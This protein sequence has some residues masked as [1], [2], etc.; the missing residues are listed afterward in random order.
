MHRRTGRVGKHAS[1][2]HGAGP[3]AVRRGSAGASPRSPAPQPSQEC[4]LWSSEPQTAGG[5][6]GSTGFQPVFSRARCPCHAWPIRFHH[7]LLV[8]LSSAL[9][10]ALSRGK[11][12]RARPGFTLV[13]LLVVAGIFAVLL[14]AIVPA[15]GTARYEAKRIVCLDHG[16]FA[17]VEFR[18]FADSYAH[19]YR[20][21]SEAYGTRFDAQDFLESLYRVGEFWP[22]ADVRYEA[23]RPADQPL[24]CPAGPPGLGRYGKVLPPWKPAVNPR[25]SVSYAFNR[26]LYRAPALRNGL[27][28]EAP[29]L[30][31]EQI[32]NHPS[33]PLFFEV[34][35]EAAL[36][37]FGSGA[38]LYDVPF[39]GTPDYF[40]R[41]TWFPAL[42]HRGRM[43]VSFVGGHALS[44]RD[45]L[46]ERQWD[47]MHFPSLGRQ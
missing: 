45:P 37:E 10:P 6:S 46:A 8:H 11:R 33:V 16:R 23:Y 21:D 22:G 32:L 38:T 19:G 13:E 4:G 42:R 2:D 27:P 14:A 17:A 26:R 24:I 28:Y 34:D 29:V 30:L 40:Q 41:N 43:T 15:M 31:T 39:F 3:L 9:T 20:G 44:T 35:A 5:R 36:K 25:E 12:G 1:A 7:G 47:W 18:L